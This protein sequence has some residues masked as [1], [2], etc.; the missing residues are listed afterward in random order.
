MKNQIKKYI[1]DLLQRADEQDKG[2]SQQKRKIKWMV[3]LGILFMFYV[4]S[5]MQSH[6]SLNHHLMKAPSGEPVADSLGNDSTQRPQ[7]P[8]ALPVDSFEQLLNQQIHEEAD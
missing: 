5:F 7:S 6:L 2:L 4:L 8:F 3:I 1:K